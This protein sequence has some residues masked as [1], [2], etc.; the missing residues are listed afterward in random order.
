M[1]EEAIRNLSIHRPE[2][3]PFLHRLTGSIVLAP[4]CR[5]SEE[6]TDDLSLPE[7]DVPVLAGAI[8]AR[9]DI[10]MTGDTRHF[11]EHFGKTVAG[12][13]IRSPIDTAQALT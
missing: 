9:C 13:T 8:T 2:A 10:L 6:I 11:G 4:I 7:K 12:V 1:V 5:W 3:I